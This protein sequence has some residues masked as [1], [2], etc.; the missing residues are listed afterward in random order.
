MRTGASCCAALERC[1]SPGLFRALGDPNRLAIL[2]ALAD[3]PRE[4]TVSEVASRC[5]VD[6]SVVSRHLRT[7]RDAGVLDAR[8]QGKEV[9]YRV[10]VGAVVA[11]LRDL[12]DA[13][14]ACCGPAASGEAPM[15]S[16]PSKGGGR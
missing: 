8:K 3:G 16:R 10:R 9:W 4:R 2:V 7:L 12:A 13:L 15:S 14:E 5:P 6:L 11:M 1:L